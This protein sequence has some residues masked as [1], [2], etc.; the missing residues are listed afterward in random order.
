MARRRAGGEW[1]DGRRNSVGSRVEGTGG[2]WLE[3]SCVVVASAEIRCNGG[4][5]VLGGGGVHDISGGFGIDSGERLAGGGPWGCRR[6][7]G[8]VGEQKV[9]RVLYKMCGSLTPAA[10]RAV[11]AKAGIDT[12]VGLHGV[13]G[14]SRELA[15]P[16]SNECPGGEE[17]RQRA[18]IV[19][20]VRGR[21]PGIWYSANV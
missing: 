21:G 12:L 5:A 7:W 11:R 14:G 8:N 13:G 19:R 1:R 18:S 17:G 16:S 6:R 20:H 15:G 2:R 9:R 4:Y 3:W 10:C